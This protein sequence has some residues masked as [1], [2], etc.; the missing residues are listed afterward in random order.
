MSELKKM[1]RTIV[2]DPFPPE[3]SISF[4]DYKLLYRKKTWKIP[5]PAKNEVIE[6]GL[7]YGENPDQPAAVYE[8]VKGNLAMS[9]CE[10]INPGN[11]LVSS[12]S[13]EDMIQAGKHPG[14]TNLT[15]IDNALNILKFLM[16]HPSAAIMKHNN[17]SGVARAETIASAY[18]RANMAD[19]IAAF[20]GCLAV[21][22][23][24][25]KSTAELV[26]ENYLEVVAAP[27]YE[28]GAVDILARRKNLRIV[29]IS[30]INELEKYMDI[31]VIE[32]KALIDAQGTIFSLP[33]RCIMERSMKYP[34]CQQKM[35][36]KI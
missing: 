32:F 24:M 19:R 30:R 18:D 26:S 13:E 9:G 36:T 31:P 12:I 6:R 7:R 29:R 34:A 4:G 27:E 14:K 21:N 8:L 17:P 23:P 16:K 33:K 11:G 25:D 5:D 15:D 3:M 35:N 28:E 10:F 22:R 1:Y 2:E 20:G